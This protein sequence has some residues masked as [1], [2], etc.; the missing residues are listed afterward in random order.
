MSL[1]K[2]AGFFGKAKI[3][4]AANSLADMMARIDPDTMTEAAVLEMESK[5][6]EI[7]L[8]VGKAKQDFDKEQAEAVVATKKFKDNEA[9]I[10]IIAGRLETDPTNAVLD[11]QLNQL[12]DLEAKLRDEMDKEVSEAAE[13]KQAWDELN[14]FAV[15]VADQLKS[16][17]TQINEA[18]RNLARAEVDNQRA[19]EREERAKVV[20][21]LKTST[22]GFSRALGSMGN[23][24][25]KLKAEADASKLRANLL[26]PSQ[27]TDLA[28]SILAGANAA[29]A[30]GSALDRLKAR[31]AQ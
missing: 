21:G 7:T 10:N 23:A 14:S 4:S 30:G 8:Q 19:K 25:D 17:R 11:G 28:A 12:L 27:P 15:E 26:T 2:L 24:T 31:Q 20:A 16:L 6:N 22:S 5:F 13:A 3:D 9:A 1:L 18:K 29:P